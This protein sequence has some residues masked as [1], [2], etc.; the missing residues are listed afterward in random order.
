MFAFVDPP[1]LREGPRLYT[2]GFT[3]DQHRQLAAALRSC[4]ARWMLT[5]DDEPVVLD[6]YADHRVL[7]YDIAHTANL[8]RVD[9]EYAVFSDNLYV[10][11]G[12]QQL[13]PR[14]TSTWMQGPDIGTLP[15]LATPTRVVRSDVRAAR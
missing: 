7:E 1:Y 2:H 11:P 10:P 12:Q 8:Q 6:L 4:P 9:R 14:G 13:L 15:G 3:L 5:Y